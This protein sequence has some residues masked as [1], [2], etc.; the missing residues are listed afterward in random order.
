MSMSKDVKKISKVVRG[1][2]EWNQSKSIWN[3][4]VENIKS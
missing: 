3:K 1:K 4:H 2:N